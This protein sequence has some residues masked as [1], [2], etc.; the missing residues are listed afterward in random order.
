MYKRQELHPY[1][2]WRLPAEER[3]RDLAAR[4]TIEQ[5]AGLMLYSSHQS[6]PGFTT[7]YF[8]KVSYEGKSLEESGLP[9]SAL[10]DQQREFIT[11][12]FLRH[13]LV[14][15]VQSPQAAAD[16]SNRLQE[17]SESLPWGI[18]IAISSDPRHGTSVT[19]EFDAGAGGDISHWPEPLGMTATFDPALVKRFGE[20]AAKEYRALGITTAQMCIRDRL[21]LSMLTA[22]QGDSTESESVVQSEVSS[23]VA[24]PVQ[25]AIQARK[26]LSLIHI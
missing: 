18:P 14:M 16:W 22:C 5:I 4:M 15:T 10:T 3:A 25:A 12:D 13:V 6:V 21:M 8:G 1:E 26:D 11:N 2:D 17:L 24:D 19:F 23:S 9:P 7:P 20:V